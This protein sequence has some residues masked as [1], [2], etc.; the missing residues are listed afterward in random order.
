MLLIAYKSVEI[1]VLLPK[2]S[3]LENQQK[4]CHFLAIFQGS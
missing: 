1:C 4:I 3:K 2:K